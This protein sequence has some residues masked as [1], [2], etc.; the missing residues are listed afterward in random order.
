MN[1][2][3][4]L[5]LCFTALLGLAWS[6]EPARAARTLELEYLANEGFLLRGG[7]RT[8]LIDAFVTEPYG[9]YA[10]VPEELF[11][12]LVSGAEGYATIDLALASHVHSDH[13]Q[14]E[15]AA[16]FLAAHAETRFVAAPE[17]VAVLEHALG[18]EATKERLL[19]RLPEAR[20]RLEERELGLEL[21]RL[22]H[23]GGVRTAAVQNL[24]HL[25]TIGGVRVLHVG[26]A[27]RES[28]ELDAHDLEG[29]NIDVA[30]VPYWWIDDSA[31]L[32]RVRALTGAREL[33]AMHV[34]PDEL[35]EVKALLA[36]IDARVLLFEKPGQRRTLRLE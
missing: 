20:A 6:Q 16:A 35:A 5:A 2:H 32:A 23:S 17:V 7:G 11:E 22:P 25:L 8:L 4:R 12:K 15:P 18:E 19:A 31:G 1:S 27:E 10:A 14:A 26:D 30:L 28:P 24:G 3:A 36:A 9:N 33:V 29:A 21:V 34:P 13:F